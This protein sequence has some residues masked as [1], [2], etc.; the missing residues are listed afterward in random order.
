MMR[1]VVPRAIR[2]LL[3]R[4]PVKVGQNGLY[5]TEV[6]LRPIRGVCIEIRKSVQIQDMFGILTSAD[7][8]QRLALE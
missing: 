3:C 5:S 4:P 1:A 7:I 6:K 8:F 2:R